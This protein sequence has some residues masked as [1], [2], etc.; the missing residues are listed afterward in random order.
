MVHR[1]F[2]AFATIEIYAALALP[3]RLEGGTGCKWRFWDAK[4]SFREFS[5]SFRG[6]RECEKV[7]MPPPRAFHFA[8]PV[9]LNHRPREIPRVYD[10]YNQTNDHSCG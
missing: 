7:G 4:M 5:E 10:V 8:P 1:L 9:G 3:V 6:R 2:E